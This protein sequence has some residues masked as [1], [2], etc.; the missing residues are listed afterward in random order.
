MHDDTT[1]W[2][3]GVTKWGVHMHVARKIA[4]RAHGLR[5]EQATN[6]A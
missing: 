6:R 3:M 5:N 1:D 2:T 4:E